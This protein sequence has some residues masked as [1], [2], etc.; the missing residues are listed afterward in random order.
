MR[1]GVHEDIHRGERAGELGP[2]QLAEE[3]GTRQLLFELTPL[4]AVSDDDQADPRHGLQRRQQRDL[5]LV[6]EPADVAHDHLAAGR[7]ST[8]QLGVTPRRVE[9]LEVDPAG[10][11]RHPVD[12]VLA[13]LGHRGPA[14]CERATGQSVHR[15]QP[16]PQ[17]A[18]EPGESVAPGEPGEVGLVDGDEG[19]VESVRREGCLRPEHS[20]GGEVHHVGTEGPERGR[21]LGPRAGQAEV[22]VTRHG[23]RR[24]PD[25]L[26]AGVAARTRTRC[27]HQHLVAP[28]L[29]LLADA[30]DAVRDSVDLGEEGLC[31]HGDSHT[32]TVDDAW[33][34]QVDCTGCSR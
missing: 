32:A 17:T 28:R 4:R 12:P 21:Q 13:Q 19:E 3:A 9:A 25:D 27:D 14:G 23:H 2:A 7:E 11:L 30:Q 20:G 31:H 1:A 22:G 16:P 10:P 34:P 6:R 18:L 8:V 26:S 15:A 29:H 33:R 5:L 24:C